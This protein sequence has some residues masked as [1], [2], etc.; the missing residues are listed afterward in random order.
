MSSSEF[1]IKQINLLLTYV[2]SC[3]DYQN[4]IE[5]WRLLDFYG[6]IHL[7]KKSHKNHE[8]LRLQKIRELGFAEV[9]FKYA[10]VFFFNNLKKENCQMMGF[11]KSTVQF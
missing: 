3:A 6:K 11:S 1:F 8:F 4:D 2:F 5:N 7:K 10:A 9:Q